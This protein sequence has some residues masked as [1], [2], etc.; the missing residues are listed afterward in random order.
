MLYVI[1]TTVTHQFA[2]VELSIFVKFQENV[3]PYVD[4]VTVFMDQIKSSYVRAAALAFDLD[5][6]HIRSLF[7]SPF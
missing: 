6:E 4:P 1:Q 5:V 7:D 3:L 2:L